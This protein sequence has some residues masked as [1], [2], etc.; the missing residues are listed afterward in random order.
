[1][2]SSHGTPNVPVVPDEPYDDHKREEDV[3]RKRDRIVWSAE[4][5]GE[6]LT[7]ATERSQGLVGKHDTRSFIGD[8]KL[9]ARL[10]LNRSAHT[11]RSEV[12]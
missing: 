6:M 7:S 3:E 1:M 5:D 10:G 8:V 11:N 12:H 2:S 9:S 4:V